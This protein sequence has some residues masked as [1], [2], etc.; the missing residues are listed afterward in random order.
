M[1]DYGGGAI[2]SPAKIPGY[3][4]TIL[5]VLWGVLLL[6]MTILQNAG[7]VQGQGVNVNLG[8]QADPVLNLVLAIVLCIYYLAIAGGGIVMARGG[9]RTISWMTA[10][11][12]TIPCCS[13]WVCIGMFPGIWAMIALS[14][15]GKEGM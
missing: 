5:A 8:T 1:G 6:V 9:S 14:R 13:P 15:A 10:I 7:V 2:S 3:L 4:I 12:A 11:A